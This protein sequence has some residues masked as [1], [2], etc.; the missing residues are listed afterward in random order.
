VQTLIVNLNFTFAKKLQC[1]ARTYNNVPCI[2]WHRFMFPLLIS[3]SRDCRAEVRTLSLRYEL[4]YRGPISCRGHNFPF[5]GEP[6]PGLGSTQWASG[7][8]SLDWSVRIMKLTT[9]FHLLA[10]LRMRGAMPPLPHRPS[11]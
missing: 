5:S 9:K 4:D 2:S 11:W 8:P 3:V 10:K 1:C 7:F 6:R